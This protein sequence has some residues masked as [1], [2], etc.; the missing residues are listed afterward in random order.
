M[1]IIWYIP[2]YG[3]MQDVYIISSMSMSGNPVESWDRVM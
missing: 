1:G 3:V 2:Y